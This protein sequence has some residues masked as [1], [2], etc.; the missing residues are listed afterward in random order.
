MSKA[1]EV[2]V[3]NACFTATVKNPLTDNEQYELTVADARLD[4]AKR[5]SC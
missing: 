2:F 3:G 1:G 5:Y 4:V